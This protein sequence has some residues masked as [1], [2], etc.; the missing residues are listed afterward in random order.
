[1]GIK[2]KTFQIT[3][4]MVVIGISFAVISYLV[5]R[6]AKDQQLRFMCQEMCNSTRPTTRYGIAEVVQY[7][8]DGSAF[9][10][11]TDGESKWVIEAR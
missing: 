10:L 8:S 6:N 9:A 4:I 3:F 2:M 7:N 11:C 5:A 1:M